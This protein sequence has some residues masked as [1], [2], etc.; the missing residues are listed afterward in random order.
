MLPRVALRKAD[1]YLTLSLHMQPMSP[2]DWVHRLDEERKILAVT[3]W[4]D[5]QQE[6]ESRPWLVAVVRM[7]EWI[8]A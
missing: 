3:V 8:W 7:R 4:Y 2:S 6:V 5:V 1:A